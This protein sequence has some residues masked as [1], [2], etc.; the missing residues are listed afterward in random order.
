M[1]KISIDITKS[2]QENA[3]DYFE[4]AKKA[5]LKIQGAKK[6]IEKTKLLLEK[7]ND[8]HNDNVLKAKLLPPPKKWYHKF[9]W[10]LTSSGALII[11]GTNASSNEALI[12]KHLDKDDLVFHT[13]M[14]GS[15]FVILKKTDPTE[16]DK[17]DAAIITACY[18]RA[19]RKKMSFIEVFYVNKDQV[20]KQAN[21]G[22]SLSTGAFVIRGKTTYLRPKTQIGIGSI[23]REGYRNEV[24][25]GSVDSCR[26]HCSRYAVIAPGDTKP[27]AI[28]KQ[29][30]VPM[31]LSVDEIVRVLPG[32]GSRVVSKPTTT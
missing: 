13:D 23:V 31:G 14:A 32:G 3:N 10:S 4:K 25:I 18:S 26:V 1:M 27:S 9:R 20:T 24:F 11:A 19:W 21:A 15:P 28:A 8:I 29:L 17:M 7:Q 22:E 16:E 2:L 30:A 6:A 5:R 12:K